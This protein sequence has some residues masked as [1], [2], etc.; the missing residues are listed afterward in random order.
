MLVLI[1]LDN[2]KEGKYTLNDVDKLLL[3]SLVISNFVEEH[4]YL[5]LEN[6]MDNATVSASNYEKIFTDITGIKDVKGFYKGYDLKTTKDANKSVYYEE[7]GKPYYIVS[8]G[9]GMETGLSVISD[10]TEK[11]E[12]TQLTIKTYDADYEN[13][14]YTHIKTTTFE[15]ETNGLRV[16]SFDVQEVK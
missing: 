7:N 2:N 5:I 11:D 16:Y 1:S 9:T 15:I 12:K 13:D 6:G 14:K 4:E 8:F 10:V 3:H